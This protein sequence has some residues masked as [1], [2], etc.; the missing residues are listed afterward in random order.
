MLN[1]HKVAVLLATYN[2][3]PWVEDQINSIINQKDVDVF[4]FASDDQSTDKTV[5]IL[6]NHKKHIRILPQIKSGG[7]ALNF[8]RLI[9]D[10]PTFDFDYIALA[11][12]DD[13]WDEF[14]LIRAINLI[15]KFNVDA[16]SSSYTAFWENGRKIYKNKS[17]FKKF[18]F[19]FESPGPGCTF[20]MKRH[21]FDSL[22]NQ[23]NKKSHLLKYINFHD[24]LIYFFA[25]ANGFKWHIDDAS[26]IYY[27]QH[28]SN[29]LGANF[30]IS[31]AIK[32]LLALLDGWLIT[33]IVAMAKFSDFSNEITKKI[34]RFN[35]S[36]RLYLLLNVFEFR[37]KRTHCIGLGITFLI[38]KK[39][40]TSI[41][42]PF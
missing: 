39:R 41:S 27:R 33:Q 4:I 16:Y 23:V 14:K 37:R 13:I 38:C 2:G 29:V 28:K 12:Q 31:A 36:D 21:I 11:D 32:R 3:E 34:E 15:D 30:G 9:K 22:R 20:V 35:F 24:S 10:S 17:G 40:F 5:D 1:K 42:L 7:A 19:I 6:K 18:D 26:Y 8:F 25:R